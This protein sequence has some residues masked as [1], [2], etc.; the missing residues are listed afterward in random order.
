MATTLTADQLEERP[1][2]IFYTGLL[3]PA[4]AYLARD[5]ASSVSEK[6]GVTTV[7]LGYTAD[8]VT[9]ENCAEFGK[10]PSPEEAWRYAL[11]AAYGPADDEFQPIDLAV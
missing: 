9:W 2:G 5:Y 7:L 4:Q 6:D 3:E 1:N 8:P 11:G 10:G